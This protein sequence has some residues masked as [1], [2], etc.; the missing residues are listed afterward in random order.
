MLIHRPMTDRPTRKPPAIATLVVPLPQGG[1][2]SHSLLGREISIG[3]DRANRIR[4]NDHFVSKFHAKLFVRRGKLTLVDLESANKTRVNGR[5]VQKSEIQVGDEVQFAGVKCELRGPDADPALEPGVSG[6]RAAIS[7]AGTTTVGGTFEAASANKTEA[8]EGSAAETFPSTG[9]LGKNDELSSS[10]VAELSVR[11]GPLP[12]ASGS[13]F[14][15]PV[16]AT[17]FVWLAVVLALLYTLGALV[18]R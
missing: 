6:V 8:E 13:G 3:R 17:T 9:K 16:R 1:E 4:I 15:L 14:Q 11:A 5:V 10:A 7:P 2:I 12:S 18:D